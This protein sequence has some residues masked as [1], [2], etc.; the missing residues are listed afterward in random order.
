MLISAFSGPERSGNVTLSQAAWVT[1]LQMRWH[2]PFW[3]LPR[4]WGAETL[5]LE[6]RGSEPRVSAVGLTLRNNEQPGWHESPVQTS[7][8]CKSKVA[9]TVWFRTLHEWP[10]SGHNHKDAER[11]GSE[12]PFSC[13]VHL[14]TWAQSPLADE[15]SRAEDPAHLTWMTAGEQVWSGAKWGRPGFPNLTLRLRS[16]QESGGDG[17]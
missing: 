14:K 11:C 9:Q 5:K 4:V 10:F 2:S 15:S 3:F 1:D 16:W 7:S 13:S 17:H 6:S 8:M 12:L